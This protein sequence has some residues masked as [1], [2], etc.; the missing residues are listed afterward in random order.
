MARRTQVIIKS[1]GTNFAP[2]KVVCV[3]PDPR[4]LAVQLYAND[5]G[6]MYF[7]LPV[8]HPALPL[9]EPLKQ[10]YFVERW[11]GNSYVTIQGGI[12]TDYDAA[13][14]EVVINGVDYMTALDKYYTPING[15]QVGDKAIPSSDTTDIGGSPSTPKGIIDAAVNKD[16]AKRAESY[17]VAVTDSAEPKC[18]HVEIFESTAASAPVDTLFAEYETDSGNKTG[19]ISLSGKL[20][21]YRNANT[22]QWIDGE[23]GKLVE[24]DFSVSASGVLI[25]AEPG[26]PLYNFIKTTDYAS[27]STDIAYSF[28]IKFRA[29][30]K[31]LSTNEDHDA[32]TSTTRR[33]S[34]LTEGVSYEF[35]AIPWYTAT[36][37]PVTGSSY[38]QTVWG[39]STGKLK[40]N[41][42]SGLITDTLSNAFTNALSNTSSP[43]YVL[44]RKNDY[45][46]VSSL[47]PNVTSETY[48]GTNYTVYRA[49]DNIPI[50][51]GDT[52]TVTG[53][54]SSLNGT[55]TALRVTRNELSATSLTE[56]W[57]ARVSG[58][59]TATNDADGKVSKTNTVLNPIV[60]FTTLEQN[61]IP[62][63]Q[64]SHP[65]ITAA[66]SPVEF[67]RQLSEVE[68]GTRTD[69]SKVVFNYYGVP[70]STPNGTKLI[71]N[72]RVSGTPQ[73]LLNYPGNINTFNVV[74][75][76]S[77]KVNSVRVVSSTP[78]LIGSSTEGT[79]GAKSKGIVRVG[80]SE[81]GDPALP[82]IVAQDGFI[83]AQG[84]ANYGMGILND[85]NLD[86][87]VTMIRVGLKTEAFGPIGVSGTP[88][89]GESVKVVIRRKNSYI[90]TDGIDDVYNV[91]GMEWRMYTDGHE[92]L[93][94]DLVKPTKFKGPAISWGSPNGVSGETGDIDMSDT[95]VK[96][97]HKKKKKEVGYDLEAA[98]DWT[99]R[100]LARILD[101]YGNYGPGGGYGFGGGGRDGN[102]RDTVSFLRFQGLLYQYGRGLTG[103][104]GGGGRGWGSAGGGVGLPKTV[105]PP[106]RPGG[107]TGGGYGQGG[108]GA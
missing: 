66:Q 62:T 36:L 68:V 50:Y 34:C 33:V 46:S 85:F 92:E 104:P 12:I 81:A 95:E 27:A 38:T 40:L 88:K 74:S 102:V 77:T 39:K 6:A 84:A 91:G 99:Q 64:S 107:S 31:Y 22:Q 90:K 94:L 28:D 49:T 80:K 63:N 37:T 73:Y 25:Y 108:G 9:I 79:S 44:D 14:N 17:S 61:N 106:S 4:D 83:S 10:H 20:V 8:G 15:P 30:S 13:N 42:T 52:F 41:Y 29:V 100:R 58:N 55:K 5:N 59:D 48:L 35:Y 2:D 105:V 3:I 65:Y 71:V 57:I 60:K 86:S 51:A 43:L 11:D 7:T 98:R 82:V 89:L 93:Y 70:G 16:T 19:I 24:G 69:R 18:G 87:D 45:P 78:F 53:L 103:A 1:M 97:K 32:G 101:K 23:T 56:I 75:K 54:S 76:K 96:K 72:H 21:I 67:L 47:C 26:G